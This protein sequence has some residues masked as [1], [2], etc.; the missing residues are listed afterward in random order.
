MGNWI[1]NCWSYCHTQR[2]LKIPKQNKGLRSI[3]LHVRRT[4]SN[5]NSRSSKSLRLQVWCMV[6]SLR[7]CENINDH[8]FHHH[9]HVLVALMVPRQYELILSFSPKQIHHII[10]HQ[11]KFKHSNFR[12]Y[13]KLLLGLAASMF[14]SREVSQHRFETWEILAGRNCARCCVFSIVSWLRGFA[15]AGPK[16][17]VAR[18]IGCPRRQQNLHH[19]CARERFG[20]QNRKKLAGSER[21]WKL[22]SP[23]FAP[24]LRATPIWKSK[25]LNTDGVGTFLRFK[26]LFACQPHKFG[27]VAKYVGGA[28]VREGCKNVGRR[29]GFEAGLKQCVSH[30]RC[31]EFV[32]CDVDVWSLRRWIRGMVANFMLRKRYFAGIISRGSNRGSYASA[33]LFRGKRNTFEASAQKSL[34]RIGILR[35][36]VWSTCHSWRNSSRNASFLIFKAWFLEDV[37]QKC[38]VLG[39]QSFMFEGNLAQKLRFWA[40]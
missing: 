10:Y 24:R 30:N 13:W 15:K 19:T 34:K 21:F 17:K 4:Q 5:H 23:K 31:R 3:S 7:R 16:S 32:L 18:R 9:L 26:M 40:A 36:S 6:S 39:L 22:V 12:L 11:R 35:S 25:S 37:S 28:G 8:H 20:D 1:W 38:F 29:G 14:D 33:Q 2:K 27:H